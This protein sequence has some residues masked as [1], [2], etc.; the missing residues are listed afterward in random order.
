MGQDLVSTE[1]VQALVFVFQ[2]KTGRFFRTILV[3]TFFMFKFLVKICLAVS[4]PYSTS[5]M[6]IRCFL[7]MPHIKN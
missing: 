2:L 3:Y 4:C 5:P 7:H 6:L 1:C